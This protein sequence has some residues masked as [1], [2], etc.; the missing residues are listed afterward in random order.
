[1]SHNPLS[2]IYDRYDG[3]ATLLSSPKALA[4]PESL[5]DRDLSSLQSHILSG[6]ISFGGILRTFGELVKVNELAENNQIDTGAVLATSA[7][8]LIMAGSIM[9]QVA[10]YSEE[11]AYEQI[12]RASRGQSYAK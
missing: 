5:S 11:F 3:I 7:E 8:L 2:Q 6:S 9:A 10:E 12:T 1:M 4:N